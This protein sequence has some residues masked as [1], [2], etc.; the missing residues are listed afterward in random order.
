MIQ[1]AGNNLLTNTNASLPNMSNTISS[2]FL[3]I[4]LEVV[5]RTLDGS[6]WVETTES[7]INTKGVVQPPRDEDLKI[8]PEGTWS[9]EWQMLHCLPNVQLKTNQY[10]K[11]DGVTYKIMAKKDWRKYGYIRYMLLEAFKA[12]LLS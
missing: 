6:D 11:Y 7:V 2:W 1:S 9:W 10:I 5:K 8:L 4:T 12:S 3:N